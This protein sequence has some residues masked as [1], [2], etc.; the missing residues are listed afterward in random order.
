MI[1][2]GAG[3]A[4]S[5][6]ARAA[7]DAGHQ[8][9]LV[10]DGRPPGTAAALAVLRPSWLRKSERGLLAD[11]V[12]LS[13]AAGAQVIIGA[14]YTRWDSPGQ[15]KTQADWVAVDPTGMC[16]EP[17]EVRTCEQ[18]DVWCTGADVPGKITHGATWVN[19]DPDALAFTGMRAHLIAPYKTMVGVAFR[20]GARL[21]SSSSVRREKSLEQA[22]LQLELADSL[23]WLRTTEGWELVEGRRVLRD[24]Q[25]TRNSDGSWTWSGFHRT[26]FALVP[27]VAR[28]IVST[29]S[30]GGFA[31]PR[32]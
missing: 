1:I 7:R 2:A 24:P 14:E 18:A 13:Q 19:P 17:D 26:G 10:S 23:G 25:L 27:A 15:A 16:L 31:F 30:G 22:R 32:E 9:L 29:V 8:V 12:M 4:G 28:E 11:S 5:W 20:S 21:G 6:L 3:L